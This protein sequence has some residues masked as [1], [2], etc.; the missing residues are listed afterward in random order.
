VFKYFI[1]FLRIF[2]LENQVSGS[3]EDPVL[4][5]KRK[6]VNKLEFEQ[7]LIKNFGELFNWTFKKLN[8]QT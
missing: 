7:K 2:T 3:L 8:K 4:N 5:P 1:N 6:K